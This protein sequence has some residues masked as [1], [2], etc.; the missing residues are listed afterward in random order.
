MQKDEITALAV[1]NAKKEIKGYL[2]LH[3]ILG[4]GGSVTISLT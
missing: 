2:H 3:D 1:I 4:R